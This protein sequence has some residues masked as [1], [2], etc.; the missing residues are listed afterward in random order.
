MISD[1]FIKIEYSIENLDIFLLRTNILKALH[2]TL[3]KLKGSLLDIGCGKMPYRKFIMEN[4][5]IEKYTGIDISGALV[6]DDTIRPDYYWDGM[7]LPFTNNQFDA[8][9]MT[10]VLEHIKNPILTLSE[11]LRVLKNG[12]ILFFTVPFLWPLHEIP[13]DEYRYTPFSLNRILE[14]SG[15]TE[16]NISAMGGWN[17]SLAH[18]LGLWAKRSD[19][20]SRKKKYFSYLLKPIIKVLINADNNTITFNEGQMTIGF[21]GTALKK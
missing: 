3:P 12:G 1:K 9:L 6:Y 13:N 19:I 14:E 8:I 20:S 11:G 18:L 17:T 7:E 2:Q 15:F 10:E 4:S 5:Q 21:Y 16:I